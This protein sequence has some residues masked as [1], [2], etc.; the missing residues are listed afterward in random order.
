[1]GIAFTIVIG[2]TLLCV[3]VVDPMIVW[4]LDHI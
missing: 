4:V 2:G 1:M 3:F